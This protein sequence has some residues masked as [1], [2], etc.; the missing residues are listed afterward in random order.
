MTRVSRDSL[1]L[2]S[3]DNIYFVYQNN[4]VKLI[5]KI[6]PDLD[7]T[8]WTL[9]TATTGFSFHNIFIDN[10]NSEIYLAGGFSGTQDFL[11]FSV[12]A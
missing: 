11:I 6:S 12:D 5:T 8:I 10:F 9:T 1:G 7:R 3:Q 4:D 2:D